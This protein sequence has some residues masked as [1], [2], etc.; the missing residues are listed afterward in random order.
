[1]RLTVTFVLAV[2]LPAASPCFAQNTAGDVTQ[3][4]RELQQTRE[5]LA[6]AV[7]QLEA[8]RKSMAELSSKV[9]ALQPAQTGALANASKVGMA[10]AESNSIEPSTDEADQD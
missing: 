6:D 1:M 5:Q 9:E 4:R 2:A 7:Q 10:T 3:L 8:M